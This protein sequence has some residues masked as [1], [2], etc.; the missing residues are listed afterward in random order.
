GPGRLHRLRPDPDRLAFA[1]RQGPR[2]ISTG[3]PQVGSWGLVTGCDR[4]YGAVGSEVTRDPFAPHARE[5]YP[6]TVAP[7]RPPGP[8]ALLLGV[9]S[10]PRR[11]SRWRC[12][13]TIRTFISRLGICSLRRGLHRCGRRFIP[14]ASP[15]R[16][17]GL[18]T[19]GNA[20]RPPSW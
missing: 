17:S 14:S 19:L 8:A 2:R 12:S 16:S 10:C 15:N 6:L 9:P 4:P 1:R 20:S 13:S 7:R 18:A 5:R 11:R 3:Y